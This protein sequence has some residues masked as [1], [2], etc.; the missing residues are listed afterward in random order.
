MMFEG[1]ARQ[2]RTLLAITL[3]ASPLTALHATPMQT[4]ISESLESSPSTLISP[5]LQ[6]ANNDEFKRIIV[7]IKEQK[8][9][10]AVTASRQLLAAHPDSAAAEELLA[11][12]LVLQ[13]HNDEGLKHLLR[14][15]KINPQQISALTKIGDIYLLRKDY[16]TAVDY[17]LRAEKIAPNDPLNEER[18][19]IAYERQGQLSMAIE[20]LEQLIRLTPEAGLTNRL[21]L[22]NLYNRSG[23][24]QKTR[25]LLAPL[26]KKDVLDILG[27]RILARSLLALHAFEDSET[28]LRKIIALDPESP[29]GYHMLG[30]LELQRKDLESAEK[31]FSQAVEKA[32]ESASSHFLLAETQR[33]NERYQE[34][35]QHYRQA[36]ELGVPDEQVK[37]AIATLEEARGKTDR[38]LKIYRQLLSQQDISAAT[39]DNIGQRHLSMLRFDA[40]E[41]AFRLFIKRF[42]DNALGPYRLG[43]TLAAQKRYPEAIDALEKADRLAPNDSNI[44]Q[45]LAIV[46]Q[47]DRQL[48]KAIKS[49]ERAVEAHPEDSMNRFTLASIYDETGDSQKSEKLYRTILA[50]EPR[51]AAALNNL[52]VLLNQSGRHEQALKL[53][54]QALAVV[55]ANPMLMDTLGWIEF[56][57]GRLQSARETLTRAA[58]AIPD[59]AAVLYHLA[60]TEHALGNDQRARELL[61]RALSGNSTFREREAAIKL[62][63]QLP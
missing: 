29:Q 45:S 47:K 8:I 46:Y 26:A 41:D 21:R 23:Q 54:K 19:A 44:L 55:P 63:Q 32:P 11:T 30:L 4:G 6:N 2:L 3:A 34:A 58:E 10:E 25:D 52:A 12:A 24:P 56:Q 59:N 35:L 28:V 61:S 27:L 37:L 53:A 5:I 42:P 43:K 31:Y 15:V 7:L 51:H 50:D 57:M 49:I 13:G 48:G 18:L 39:I 60:A 20:K 1:P 62:Q 14:A 40:A 22:A 38:A 9:D 33:Q 36:A 16:A 17:L